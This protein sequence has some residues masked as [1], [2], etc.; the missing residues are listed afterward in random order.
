MLI[1]PPP[2]YFQERLEEIYETVDT[3]TETY[4]NTL[5]N[6]LGTRMDSYGRFRQRWL[7][8]SKFYASMSMD[9]VHQMLNMAKE[10][11]E[12]AKQTRT[13]LKNLSQNF[14][15]KVSLK[16]ELLECIF[17]KVLAYEIWI[18]KFDICLRSKKDKSNQ[19]KKESEPYQSVRTDRARNDKKLPPPQST[20]TYF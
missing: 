6:V 18:L 16:Q 9:E 10:R 11:L 7:P 13:Q 4:I 2:P 15:G 8:R 5:H 1:P 17:S 19:I 20:P 3:H 12:T 14:P